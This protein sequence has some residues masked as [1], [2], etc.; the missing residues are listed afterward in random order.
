MRTFSTNPATGASQFRAYQG[1]HAI[2]HWDGGA[3]SPQRY[4][5]GPGGH[6]ALDTGT[7]L[8][9]YHHDT[10][11]SV[12]GL[13]DATGAL[14][15]KKRFDPWG[16]TLEQPANPTGLERQPHGFTGHE[17]DAATGLV[18]MKARYYAPEL[19]MF[20]SEDPVF[21]NLQDPRSMRKHLYAHGDPVNRWD[22][23]GLSTK[24]VGQHANSSGGLPGAYNQSTAL[25]F[26]N[27]AE[28]DWGAY[29]TYQ[30]NVSYLASADRLSAMAQFRMDT[31]VEDYLKERIHEQIPET[32]SL[33][34]DALGIMYESANTFS[35]T[36]ID[37]YT[38][39]QYAIG[40]LLATGGLIAMAMISPTFMFAM[41]IVGPSMM[42]AGLVTVGPVTMMQAS[43]QPFVNTY[44][45][46]ANGWDATVGDYFGGGMGLPGLV[47][48][49]VQFSRF[50]L[51]MASKGA[52]FLSAH[53]IAA[54]AGKTSTKLRGFSK[55][56]SNQTQDSL[57]SVK[58]RVQGN[59]STKGKR[60]GCPSCFVGDT[61]V[62]MCDGET[63]PIEE[64]K[65]GDW[66]WS[67]D[68]VTKDEGCFEVTHVHTNELPGVYE[69]TLED[70]DTGARDTVRVSGAHP[71]MTPGA[72]QRIVEDLDLGD[73]VGARSEKILRLVGKRWF[74]KG[75]WRVYNL[76]IAS[77]H[78]YFVGKSHIWVHN[79]S[80][81]TGDC[82]ITHL[83]G[84]NIEQ[85][86]ARLLPGRSH[87]VQ[88]AQAWGD[89]LAFSVQRAYGANNNHS[90]ATGVF[91][92]SSR[93]DGSVSL[94][95]GR[96]NRMSRTE[97][98]RILGVL[99]DLRANQKF[100]SNDELPVH[101]STNT[102]APSW[103]LR[104]NR[105]HAEPQMTDGLP[106]NHR[107]VS[108]RTVATRHDSETGL[109]RI[110]PLEACQM[111]RMSYIIRGGR[112]RGLGSDQTF[113]RSGHNERYGSIRSIPNEHHDLIP[114][115]MPATPFVRPSNW[116]QQFG[117]GPV[118]SL[119]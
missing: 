30:A 52:N 101:I 66:V 108:T 26:P 83:L 118:Y 114:T 23:M 32:L 13:S 110:V 99:S 67:K 102:R 6:F 100:P 12:L 7:E 63:K 5:N 103:W 17:H 112:S 75:Q 45:A 55:K 34:V 24:F 84:S 89:V 92:M 9:F 86:P 39:A 77:F 44:M 47:A 95:I 80:V 20:L 109:T 97:R 60:G 19:G 58:P 18:Y 90:V 88:E 11:G 14:V 91:T 31:Q 117:Y 54:L 3:T 46:H 21:G 27:Y 93:I 98:D 8:G 82:D 73:V 61:P 107:I 56:S 35:K 1:A 49:P 41:T 79:T 65:A 50:A 119:P 28:F 53:S 115:N 68:A 42:A 72:T 74:G 25:S 87:Q 81:P 105:A 16:R 113:F 2:L 38:G 40:G 48:A 43:M 62:L 111:C 69:L 59:K 51:S 10:Q 70:E 15:G 85:N 4:H 116:P 36:R 64:V 57:N 76:T 96:N 37:G 104:A 29:R 71:F 106:S 33:G 94:L 78:T 22:P